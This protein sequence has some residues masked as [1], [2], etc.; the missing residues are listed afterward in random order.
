LDPSI[1]KATVQ[2]DAIPVLRPQLP[3][4]DRLLPYLR[5]I[6]ATRYYSNHGPLVLE[7]ERRLA[8][9]LA[10]PPGG[11]STAASGT[12]ALIGAIIASAGR[13]TPERPL[14]LI[15]SF[16]FVATAVAAEPCGYHPFLIDVDPDTW[17]LD[18][19][20]VAKCPEC[21]RAGIVIPVS[22]F[23]RPVPLPP[24]RAFQEQT[25]IRVVV[26]GAASFEGLSDDPDRYLSSIPVAL[27]FHATKS[28]ATGEGGAIA[29]TDL[30]LATRAVQALNF[31]FYG[32]HNSRSPSINGK[33]SEYHAAVGLA[34]FD[35]WPAKRAALRAVADRYRQCLAEQG[36]PN[37]LFASPDIGSCYVLF[38]C[39]DA[40]QTAWIQD[41]LRYNGIDFRLWYGE[42][43]HRQSY[44]AGVPHGPLDV[45]DRILPHLLG[46]PVALDLSE[47]A[48][49][50]IG[51][52][53]GAG[54]RAQEGRRV[55]V[56]ARKT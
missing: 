11:V 34:E 13:A 18:A 30:D 40:Q 37:R 3:S 6:D 43:L 24:W 22:P 23:G 2:R 28:F 27:S 33:M 54:I 46:L 42:G 55:G 35:G 48:I 44:Y 51:A 29:T 9:H 31:G 19:Y 41:T 4:A 25:G 52:S 53:L 20:R 14:A 56:A 32:S 8:K 15:P 36:L 5:Q 49:T 38:H 39:V 17:M 45:T 7:L 10:I 47:A 21:D 12:A 26:D 1:F 50:L 16:T